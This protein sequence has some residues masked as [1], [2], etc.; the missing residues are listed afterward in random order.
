MCCRPDT[1]KY[2]RLL[3]S[4]LEQAVMLRKFHEHIEKTPNLGLLKR[5]CWFVMVVVGLIAEKVWGTAVKKA[6][7]G[8]LNWIRSSA[9]LL[10]L[11][12][13]LF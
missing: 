2:I 3:K 10:C 1:T 9:L 12:L 13:V 11:L 8:H 7:V 6:V 5:G 4:V